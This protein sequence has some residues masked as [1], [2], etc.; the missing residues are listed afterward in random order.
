MAGS[1]RSVPQ[2]SDGVMECHPDRVSLTGMTVDGATEAFKE[3]NAAYS[4]LAH[5]YGK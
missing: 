1:H 5:E 2:K 4:F 3:V